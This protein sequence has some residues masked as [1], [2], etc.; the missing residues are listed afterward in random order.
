MP[1]R[2]TVTVTHL[3]RSEMVER[4][5][6]HYADSTPGDDRDPD[7]P[8]RIAALPAH[9]LIVMY[10]QVVNVDEA[11][12]VARALKRRLHAAG[13]AF[14]CYLAISLATGV[15]IATLRDDGTG[16]VEYLG[17]AVAV[18]ALVALGTYVFAQTVVRRR[19]RD[20]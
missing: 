18:V 11:A 15:R 2:H 4:V 9:D 19:R 13:I 16:G 8:A 5:Q 1:H 6:Q 14:W 20:R 3:T 17:G 12:H 10:Q 7:V